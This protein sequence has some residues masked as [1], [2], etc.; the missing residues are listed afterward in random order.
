MRQLSPTD[1]TGLKAVI[2][3]RHLRF[4]KVKSRCFELGQRGTCPEYMISPLKASFCDN[5]S[6]LEGE[7]LALEMLLKWLLAS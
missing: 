3:V 2:T 7:R 4:F 6:H 5:V 1:K